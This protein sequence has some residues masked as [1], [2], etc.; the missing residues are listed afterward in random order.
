M[1]YDKPVHRISVVNTGVIGTSWAAQYLARGVDVIAA[2]PDL[3]A[4]AKLRTYVD[5]AW[6]ALTAIGLAQGAL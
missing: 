4:K 5:D 1:K 3:H 6:P 2:D